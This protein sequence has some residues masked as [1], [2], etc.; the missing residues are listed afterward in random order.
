MARVERPHLPH[1]PIRP[2]DL[3]LATVA[4]GGLAVA[5]GVVADQSGIFAT[6]SNDEGRNRITVPL[7]S[8]TP[9]PTLTW[10]P[11]P[12]PT[13]SPEP[14]P[15]PTLVPPSPTRVPVF[16]TAIPPT[17]RPRPT[18]APP[19]VDHFDD[20]K[21]SALFQLV[22]SYR[23]ERGLRPF[24][25][26]SR[27]TTAAREYAKVIAPLKLQSHT[28]PDGST[29]QSRI[30]R[31]GY[32]WWQAAG[33]NIMSAWGSSESVIWTAEQM[34]QS[35]KGSSGH[36]DILL[37]S[38]INGGLGCYVAK[39]PDGSFWKSCVLDLASPK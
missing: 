22:N 33:E 23:A 18:E 26:D 24:T 7:P 8:A 37:G 1:I 3:L 4:I 14:T 39:T 31:A 12:M 29:L 11:T 5:G 10:T 30:E 6:G 13:P 38:Y 17:A 36:N 16:P 19:F 28:G 27:L 20:A 34:L 21:A 2:R 15:I 32:V 25:Q 9:E 35:W